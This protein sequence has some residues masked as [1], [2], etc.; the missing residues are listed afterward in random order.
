M[1]AMGRTIEERMGIKQGVKKRR[2]KAEKDENR[3][4]RKLKNQLKESRRMVAW[5]SNEIYRRKWKRKATK[6]EKEILEKLRNK[7]QNELA[8]TEEL[9]KEKEKWLQELRYRKTKS[10]KMRTRDEK[11]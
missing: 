5:L 9:H 3:R 4:L 6:R 2:R 11:I 7:T 8:T 1:Y 10:E